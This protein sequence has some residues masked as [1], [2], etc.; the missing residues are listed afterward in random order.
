[1]ILRWNHK[2][3]IK[4]LHKSILPTGTWILCKLSRKKEFTPKAYSLSYALFKSVALVL[5]HKITHY[6]LVA[7]C[8]IWQEEFF[9][10]KYQ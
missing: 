1:M 3:N 8:R 10:T 7:H 5:I 6:Y 4:F 2:Y 9:L